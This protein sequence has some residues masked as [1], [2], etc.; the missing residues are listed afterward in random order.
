MN[1]NDNMYG[2]SREQE[3]EMQNNPRTNANTNDLDSRSN[4]GDNSGM[5]AGG[6]QGSSYQR[7]QPENSSQYGS[8][9]GSYWE[10][11]GSDREQ[12]AENRMN[13]QNPDKALYAAMRR[14]QR[15]VRRRPSPRNTTGS[16]GLCDE[17]PGK[18]RPPTCST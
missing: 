15:D 1:K 8:K 18:N 14:P 3:N 7:Q 10:E 4:S 6:N 17:P 13:G 12:S 2:E 5:H 16:G 9:T 11:K